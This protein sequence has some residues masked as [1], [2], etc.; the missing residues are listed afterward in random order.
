MSATPSPSCVRS[1]MVAVTIFASPRT[2]LSPRLEV[3][4]QVLPIGL[5]ELGFDLL[6]LA[7][8]GH[9]IELAAHEL[10]T[11][12]DQ[13]CVQHIGLA[14]VADRGQLAALVTRPHVCSAD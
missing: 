10:E 6:Q 13:I 3:Q 11:Q 5:L 14:V 7:L 2:R 9:R 1:T 12:I 4:L 8:V